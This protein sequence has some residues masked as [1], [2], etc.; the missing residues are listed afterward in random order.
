MTPSPSPV[1]R[2]ASSAAPPTCPGHCQHHL[3]PAIPSLVRSAPLESSLLGQLVLPWAKFH[4]SLPPPAPH[5]PRWQRA[6]LSLLS[7]LRDLHG[8][9]LGREAVSSSLPPARVTPCFFL[10]RYSHSPPPALT[11]SPGVRA[12][13][14]GSGP[15]NVGE[16]PGKAGQAGSCHSDQQIPL[17]P[18]SNRQSSAGPN[19][20]APFRCPGVLIKSYRLD[21]GH[22]QLERG[23][24]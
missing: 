10:F 1:S 6:L 19:T 18:A 8:P 17:P 21:C 5:Q 3:L 14:S 12:S 11:F 16:D 2:L 23:S 4:F 15:V 20:S 22:H 9:Y 7:D 13:E 24:A